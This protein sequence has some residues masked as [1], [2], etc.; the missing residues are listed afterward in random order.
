MGVIVCVTMLFA[1][2]GIVLSQR[3]IDLFYDFSD[4]DD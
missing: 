2:I 4:D 1:L 3:E